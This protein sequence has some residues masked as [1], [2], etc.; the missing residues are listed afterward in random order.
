MLPTNPTPLR[1]S[2]GTFA[3][4][5]IELLIVV[6]I[7]AIL[8]SIAVVN[9]REATER[10]LKASNA[11]N[12]HTIITALQ[13]YVVDHNKLPPADGTAGPYDSTGSTDFGNGPAAGG[14]WSGVPWLLVD[15]KYISNWQTLFNPKYLKLYPGGT[16]I[17]GGHPRFH[18][19]RYAYNAA[20]RDA[21]VLSGGQGNISTGNAWVVRDLY[22]HPSQGAY[23]TQYPRAPADF[24]YPWGEMR[25]QEHVMFLDGSV[26]LVY[27]GSNRLP[28]AE[29]ERLPWDANRM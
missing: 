29:D 21:G 24:A 28:T 26:R 25:N 17:R 12:L 7:I 5:L 20:A 3:F 6:S 10:S 1:R 2:P 9:F 4:T 22:L 27:G 11:A 16:T 18:N 23:A 14:S 8:A 13:T 19:F 15:L